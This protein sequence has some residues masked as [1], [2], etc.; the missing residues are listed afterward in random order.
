MATQPMAIQRPQFTVKQQATILPVHILQ[1]FAE[2]VVRWTEAFPQKDYVVNYDFFH[3]ETAGGGMGKGSYTNKGSRDREEF[4]VTHI[5]GVGPG[6][7]AGDVLEV[8]T[9]VIPDKT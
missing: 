4:G 3:L 5:V 1:G 2:V 8:E 6:A 7:V 9:I